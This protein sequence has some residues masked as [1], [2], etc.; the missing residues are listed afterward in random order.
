MLQG[1]HWWTHIIRNAYLM[2]LNL[3]SR[4]LKRRWC[5]QC[6]WHHPQAAAG[7]EQCHKD[8]S[9]S[10]KMWTITCASASEGTALV[11]DG[12]AHLQQAGCADIQD[13]AYRTGISLS[14]HQGSTQRHSVSAIIGCSVCQCAV[15]THWYRQTILQLHCVCNLELCPFCCHKLS[16]SLYIYVQA[17]TAS[18]PNSGHT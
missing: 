12:A 5:W 1:P 13:M 10:A 4:L 6:G 8:R 16:C 11:A 3:N 18:L 9:S 7:T 17:T 2:H 15:Q 14:A